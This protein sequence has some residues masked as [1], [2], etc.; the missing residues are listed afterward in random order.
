MNKTLYILIGPQGSGKSYWALNSLHAVK[1][2]NPGVARVS[3]DEMGKAGHMLRF[4]Q[5]LESGASVLVDRM[6]H[7]RVQRA[8]Y[9]KPAREQG[10]RV[11][12]VWFDVDR[13]VCLKRLALRKGHPTVGPDADHDRL[14]GFYFA[15]FEQP[16]SDEYDELKVVSKRVY[17]KILDIREESR[18]RKVIVVG[19]IHGC[20]DE[21]MHLLAECNYEP[22]DLVVAT[23]D[24]VDR[25]PKSK[26]TLEWFQNT[27][28][29]RTV[30]GNHDNK[31]RRYWAGRKV[32]IAHGLDT[33]IE[34]CREM[35]HA[36]LDSWIASWPHII[37]VPDI[38]ERPVYVVHA[39]FDGR[40]PV[41]RQKVE[42]CLYARHLGGR[43]FFD[44]SGT[45]WW[46]TLDGSYIVI[47]GHIMRD[48]PQPS[49]SVYCLDGGA[50]NGGTLRALVL[51]DGQCELVQVDSEKYVEDV[52]DPDPV[53]ERDKLVESG[54]LRCDDLGDLRVYTYT[55]SCVFSRNWTDITLNSR[56]HVLNRKTGEMVACSFPK[57]FNLGERPE[58]AESVLP[59]DG[60]FTAFEKVD[61]WLGNLYRYNGSFAISTRG[62]FH[63]PGAEWAT[64]FL[65]EK[66]DLA[67]LPDEVTLVFELVSPLT[68]IIVNYGEK[69]DLVL[70]AAFNRHTGEEF[71]RSQVATWAR[72]YGFSLPKIFR[73]TVQKFRQLLANI[74]GRQAEG[75][76]IRFANGLRVKMKAEDYVRRAK[77][78]SNLTPL[79]V[80]GAMLG[81][82]LN[83]TY[84]ES[85]D[86]DYLDKLDAIA[87]ELE[88]QFVAINCE[89]EVD[90]ALALR[91]ERDRDENRKAFAELIATAK[92]RHRAVMF[93]RLDCKGSAIEKYIMS[94]IRPHNN[95]MQVVASEVH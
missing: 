40:W 17:G 8:R 52:T 3:Q 49:E 62:S 39:G 50:Y 37:R 18:D 44:E 88:A 53:S 87:E 92:L 25:G 5:C 31:A 91:S 79:S 54:M 36:A 59:W 38:D 75:F 65:Q 64:Q 23:G 7:D 42:I 60:G 24:L 93:A 27:P 45:P 74:D 80:W 26:E 9:I 90:F 57:F 78:V 70:L 29:A 67:G 84:R 12:F 10:Y 28:G 21:F 34:Q 35:D 22:G 30:E 72:R 82:R 6:N 66:Y 58:T 16:S 14:L 41:D 55:D 76:V 11:V 71:S 43:D 48:N 1:P 95:E 20:F 94:L 73:G 46:E 85:V 47:S 33:T 89:I 56:G 83:R 69:E 32:T 4:Q 81:G 86:G 13:E 61:G 2:G 15:R 51:K 19:D 77:I 63:S 68:K